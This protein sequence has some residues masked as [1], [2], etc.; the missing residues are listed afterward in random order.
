MPHLPLIAPAESGLAGDLARQLAA[1]VGPAVAAP[2][3]S[4]AGAECIALGGALRDARAATLFALAQA[5]P[6]TATD[7]LGEWEAMLAIPVS[8]GASDAT[9]QAA[10]LARL[11]A[12]GGT[13]QRIEAA[14]TTL[15]GATI[16][17]VEYL[18]SAFTAT[19]TPRLVFRFT[20]VLSAALYAD[21]AFRAALDELLQRQVPAHCT[22]GVASAAAFM[23]DTA[24]AG[25]DLAPWA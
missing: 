3:D 16:T 4:R 12:F 2:D 23:W 7:L 13:P 6:Q 14:A 9:R 20:V 8:P 1:L 25:W 10:L 19:A 17:V 11:R 18:Y 15:A 24:D 22:W 21:T 5:V